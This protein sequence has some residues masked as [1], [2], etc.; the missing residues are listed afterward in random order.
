MRYR[1]LASLDAARM[2]FLFPLE[3]EEENSFPSLGI[4]FGDNFGGCA[5]KVIGISHLGRLAL[6][7]IDSQW[8]RIADWETK[9]ARKL[10][11]GNGLLQAFFSQVGKLVYRPCQ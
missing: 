11:A 7:E 9:R 8:M 6:R 2:L 10:H 5:R 4:Y 1:L 3:W